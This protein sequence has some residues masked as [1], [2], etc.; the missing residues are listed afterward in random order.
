MRPVCVL[1]ACVCVVL[2][3][4]QLHSS[5][6]FWPNSCASTKTSF[7]YAYFVSPTQCTHAIW[8]PIPK[9]SRWIKDSTPNVNCSVWVQRSFPFS[10]GDKNIKLWSAF[11]VNCIVIIHI[12]F[13]TKDFIFNF[14]STIQWNKFLLNT[15]FIKSI[16]FPLL[17]Y[18]DGFGIKQPMMVDM[19]LNKETRTNQKYIVSNGDY[20]EKKCFITENLLYFTVLLS[21]Q[22]ICL[23][24][25]VR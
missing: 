6:K 18:K 9:K 5:P 7:L 4:I 2:R 21:S 20:V 25:N 3:C 8:K 14:A 24:S 10:D 15:L 22:A 11:D 16:Q 19:P 1:D 17:F 13:P 23:M 12:L